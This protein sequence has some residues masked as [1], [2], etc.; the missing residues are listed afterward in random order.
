MEEIDTKNNENINPYFIVEFRGAYLT[1]KPGELDKCKDEKNHTSEDQAAKRQLLQL[2]SS[3]LR[4][5]Q[6]VTNGNPVSH[7]AEAKQTS[8]STNDLDVPVSLG[9]P[10]LLNISFSLQKVIY[11]I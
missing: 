5:E 1:W 2:T 6:C 10:V 7:A 9:S 8:L 3:H 4:E 11:I